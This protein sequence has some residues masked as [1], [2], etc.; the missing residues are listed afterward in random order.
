M[1]TMNDRQ[2]ENPVLK[3]YGEL[4]YGRGLAAFRA[5][6]EKVLQTG[7]PKDVIVDLEAVKGVDSSGIGELVRAFRRVSAAGGRL[8]LLRPPAKVRRFLDATGLSSVF[9]LQ[10]PPKFLFDQTA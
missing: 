6:I 4:C 3:V 2:S 5:R 8:T 10:D 7:Q 9:G 1:M